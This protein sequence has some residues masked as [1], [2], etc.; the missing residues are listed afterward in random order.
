MTSVLIK[1]GNLD[2]ERDTERENDVKTQGEVSQLQGTPKIANKPSEARK[3]TWNSS[4]PV[5]KTRQHAQYG[6][7]Y[8]NPY[9]TKPRLNLVNG[10]S[11]PRNGILNQSMRNHLISTS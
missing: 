8:A 4:F 11:C 6:V 1:R 9:I 2:T 10:F 5:L 3:E 7:A